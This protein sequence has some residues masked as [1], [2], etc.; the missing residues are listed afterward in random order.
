[1]LGQ[2]PAKDVAEI[3][4]IVLLAYHMREADRVEA[5]IQEAGQKNR[6]HELWPVFQKA[7]EDEEMALS[8]FT[9]YIM[10]QLDGGDVQ[11]SERFGI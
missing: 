9:Q 1:M 7:S 2:L 4:A 3:V 11:L 8:H 5:I 10:A 6:W